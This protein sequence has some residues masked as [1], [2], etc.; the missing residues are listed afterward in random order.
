MN[1]WNMNYYTANPFGLAPFYWANEQGAL[2]GAV[3]AYF[4]WILEGRSPAAEQVELLCDYARYW[5][6]APCW[7]DDD[8]ELVLAELRERARTLASL[9]SLERWIAEAMSVGIDPF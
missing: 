4:D 5:I 2:P 7:R 6:N 9:E 3:E 1:R 8:G